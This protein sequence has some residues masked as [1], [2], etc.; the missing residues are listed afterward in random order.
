MWWVILDQLSNALSDVCAVLYHVVLR[1]AIYVMPCNTMLCHVMPHWTILCHVEPCYVMLWF[2]MLCLC[3]AVQCCTRLCR[4]SSVVHGPITSSLPCHIIEVP[5]VKDG[6]SLW[7]EF[8]KS[9]DSN[10][11]RWLEYPEGIYRITRNPLQALSSTTKSD[12]SKLGT[13]ADAV[14]STEKPRNG[15]VGKWFLMPSFPIW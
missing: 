15:D 13:E 5:L 6:W 1:G 11:K 8:H 14:S 10:K 9:I 3:M 4:S 2:I 7:L 12:V